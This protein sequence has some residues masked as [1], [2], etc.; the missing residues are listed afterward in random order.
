MVKQKKRELIFETHT[1]KK[2]FE[3]NLEKNDDSK[4]YTQ[5]ISII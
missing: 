2:Y 1:Y 3:Q 5:G 4:R